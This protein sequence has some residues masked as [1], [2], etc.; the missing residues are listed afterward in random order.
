MPEF[1]K[2]KD[3]LNLHFPGRVSETQM[4]QFQVAFEGYLDWNDRVN[5]V[6]RKDLEN[7]ADRHFLHSLS[8]AKIIDFNPKTRII[9]AGTGG[10]FPGIPLAIFFPE[11]QFTLV[12]SI[13]KKLRA[14]EDIAEM[15]GLKNVQINVHRLEELSGQWD[16]AV[17]RALADWGTLLPWLKGKIKP[18]GS[19]DLPNG[20]LY[21]KGGAPAEEIAKIQF[22]RRKFKVW[23]LKEWFEDE[24][25]E[26]KILAWVSPA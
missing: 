18:G 15:A 22:L 24:W 21:L 16:F 17:S 13:R 5:L 6:S 4:H 14:A 10:G 25:F 11:V 2:L 12:D 8:I 26:T 3:L 9:D 7:L 1:Q 20:I 19:H 23:E